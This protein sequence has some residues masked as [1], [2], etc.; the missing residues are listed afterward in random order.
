MIIIYITL[1]FLFGFISH[2]FVMSLK[3]KKK[4]PIKYL[5]R[6][7]Y[8]HT[9]TVGGSNNQVNVLYEIGEI[10]STSKKSKIDVLSLKTDRSEYNSDENMLDKLKNMI[11]GSWINTSEV[12]W[13]DSTARERDEKIEKIL[14]K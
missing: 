9:F 6:G 4:D 12:E 10:E 2:F 11:H 3:S 1:V 8:S 13:I 14:S 7:I 5:R